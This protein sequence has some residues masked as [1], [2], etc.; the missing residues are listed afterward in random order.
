MSI[1][2]IGT[3][4]T[5][6]DIDVTERVL[7]IPSAPVEYSWWGEIP[8][9]P[10]IN[11]QVRSDDLLFH[12]HHPASLFYDR[13]MENVAVVVAQAGF[14]RWEGIIGNAAIQPGGRVVQ[15]TCESEFQRRS[16]R[17]GQVDS[18]TL[19]PARAALRMLKLWDIPVDE[20][21]F[22]TADSI[23]DDIPVKV[24]LAPDSLNTEGSLADILQNLA[25]AG[26]LRFRVNQRG[27]VECNSW[28]PFPSDPPIA[29]DITDSD[30]MEHPTLDTIALDPLD[31][32]VIQWMHGEDK[33]TRQGKR[34]LALDFGPQQNVRMQSA[35]AAIYVGSQW[36]ELHRQ[37]LGRIRIAVD[38]ELGLGLQGERWISLSSSVLGLTNAPVE[39]VG[40]D[41]TDKRWMALMG[42]IDLDGRLT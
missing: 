8:V 38:R 4:I 6:D 26:L 30:L 5:I 2:N 39:L 42:H 23:L 3:T 33:D 10:S 24:I 36:R 31:G 34:I 20:G 35:E 32:W 15:L 29:A 37:R 28:T 19:T 14:S 27:E 25:A 9:S 1:G 17:M 41:D 12:P 22:S 18:E 16:V 13:E 21:S 7:T 11:L 40:W